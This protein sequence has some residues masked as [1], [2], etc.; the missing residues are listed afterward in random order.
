[1]R[2]QLMWIA[3]RKRYGLTIAH[4]AGA[5][6]PVTSLAVTLAVTLVSYRAPARLTPPAPPP[7]PVS[8][9][10]S[11]SSPSPRGNL[12]VDV[13]YDGTVTML[14]NLAGKHGSEISQLGAIRL[15]LTRVCPSPARQIP[16]ARGRA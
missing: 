7:C 10:L 11:R 15:R 13:S 12:L 2:H 16:R 1:M 8:L 5:F 4:R 6:R 14:V 9:A 3:F